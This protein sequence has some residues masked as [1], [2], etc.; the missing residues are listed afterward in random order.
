MSEKN[1][2]NNELKKAFIMLSDIIIDSY[3]SKLNEKGN[4]LSKNKQRST[5]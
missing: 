3:L 2:K 4:H 5:N 1:K